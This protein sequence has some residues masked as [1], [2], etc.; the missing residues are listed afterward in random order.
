MGGVRDITYHMPQI[1]TPVVTE[2]A[3]MTKMAEL[4]RRDFAVIFAVT[5]GNGTGKTHLA[6]RLLANLPFHQ[7]FNLGLVTKTIRCLTDMNDVTMLENFRDVRADALF[8]RVIQYSCDEYQ[9]NGVN[10]LIDGV[11]ID[12]EVLGDDTAILG[13]IILNVAKPIRLQRNDR[14]T[15]HFKRTLVVQSEA[16]MPHYVENEGFRAIDNSGSFDETYRATLEWLDRLLDKKL[17][18]V[19]DNV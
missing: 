11:Q 10:V 8:L 6:K 14:P 18:E 2:A 4:N 3:I 1:N 7:S 16:D 15:T 19:N 12:S 13:G 9:R 5:G 17:D